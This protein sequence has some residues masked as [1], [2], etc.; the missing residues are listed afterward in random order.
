MDGP[1]GECRQPPPATVDA[2]PSSFHDCHF[3]FQRSRSGR[4][5]S[6]GTLAHARMKRTSRKQLQDIE[7]R[8]ITLKDSK[9]RTR[10]YMQAADDCT[11]IAL[12]GE[13]GQSVQIK[14]TPDGWLGMEIRDSTGRVAIGLSIR[15]DGN[16]GLS[17]MDHRSGMM[18]LI[19]AQQDSPAH[20]ISVFQHGKVHW[21]SH[22]SARRGT[23]RP[24]SR[25]AE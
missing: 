22:K 10:V 6:L 9:G 21:T 17:V 7:A 8:S 19:G 23:R 14:D 15:A 25:P 1:T 11:V 2:R 13:K 5:S 12:Y 20:E 16:P 3:G 4:G 24:G 18:S